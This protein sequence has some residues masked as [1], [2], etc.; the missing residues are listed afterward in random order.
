MSTRVDVVANAR[1]TGSTSSASRGRTRKKSRSSDSRWWRW[2]AESAAPPPNTSSRARALADTTSSA[3][4][5]HA[6]SSGGRSALLFD[7]DFDK[8]PD[9]ACDGHAWQEAR[10][11]IRREL[12]ELFPQTSLEYR[13]QDRREQLRLAVHIDRTP[14]AIPCPDPSGTC[15]GDSITRRPEPRARDHL[16]GGRWYDWLGRR[17]RRSLQRLRCGGRRR[18]RT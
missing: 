10:D 18:R 7:P 8:P 15:H 6:R 14:P 17:R 3:R 13:L 9:V 12:L 2:I 11:G 4:C 5:C 16:V 1:P